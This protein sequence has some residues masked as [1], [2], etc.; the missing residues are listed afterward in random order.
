MPYIKQEDRNK[1]DI[2]IE[3]LCQALSQ[4]NNEGEYN[5]AITKLI[6][7][8]VA[9]KGKNYKTLNSAVGILECAKAEFIRVVVSPYED[10]KIKEN[11]AV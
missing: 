11:G 6:H 10:I 7:N 5:Y 8:Y 2:Y 9:S 1:L 3:E 4:D